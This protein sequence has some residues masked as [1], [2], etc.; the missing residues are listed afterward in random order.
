MTTFNSFRMGAPTAFAT[1]WCTED[2]RLELP[3]TGSAADVEG[4]S[5][6]T[7][8]R[9]TG[10]RNFNCGRLVGY[11]GFKKAHS[12][13]AQIIASGDCPASR[14]SG[15]DCPAMATILFRYAMTTI[16]SL[17]FLLSL[18]SSSSSSWSCC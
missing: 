17:L 16:F 5:L 12:G 13:V 1:V 15:L 14:P 4:L 2:S 3:H 6:I 9:M 10:R 8:F 11:L 18:L 7:N